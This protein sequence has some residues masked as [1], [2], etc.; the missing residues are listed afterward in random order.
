M[1]LNAY[2]D[3]ALI[4]QGGGKVVAVARN[5][6]HHFSKEQTDRI[7]VIAGEGVVGDAHRGVTV[8]HRS[9]VA[10]DPD[11][12]NLRQVYLLQCELFDEL[13]AKGFVIKPGDIGENITTSGIDLLALPYGTYLHIGSA[14]LQVTGLR[15]PCVQLNNFRPGLMDA[16]LDKAEDGGLIRKAG[17]MTIVMQA[18]VIRTGDAITITLPDGPHKALAVV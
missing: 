5:A 7:E 13:A 6:M 11:Q 12:P 14:I 1:K 9:R 15:N 2:A 17:V 8:K 16:V 18:G 4:M 3:K 10:K